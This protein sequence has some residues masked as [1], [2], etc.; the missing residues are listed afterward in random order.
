MNNYDRG[1][2]KWLP[3]NSVISGKHMVKEI[4]KEKRKQ[5]MPILSYEQKLAIQNKILCAFYEQEKIKITYYYNG[6]FFMLEGTIKKIDS[7]YHKI[8]FNNKTL[9]FDQIINVS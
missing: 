8:Y 9:I 4:L 1:M 5:K 2:I 3:F 7:T 6:K